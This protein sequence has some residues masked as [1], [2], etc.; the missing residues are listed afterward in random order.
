MRLEEALA[1]L[2][3][4]IDRALVSGLTEFS[5]VH[6][7]GEGVLQRGIHDFLKNSPQVKDYHFS[8]PEQGGFGRT[9]V[10]L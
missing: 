6:G 7:L 10:R 2:E 9:V 8:A 4:Q 1:R 3:Q 5:V